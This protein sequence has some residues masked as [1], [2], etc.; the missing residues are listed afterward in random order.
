[1]RPSALE[2]RAAWNRANFF[3]HIVGMLMATTKNEVPKR[4]WVW[5]ALAIY[6]LLL[7]LSHWIRVRDKPVPVPEDIKN[8]EVA[9]V[10]GDVLLEFRYDWPIGNMFSSEAPWQLAL[11][12]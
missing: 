1:M 9:A 6:A 8:V 12:C 10:E 11:R 4:R 3:W 7:I 2:H 5:K